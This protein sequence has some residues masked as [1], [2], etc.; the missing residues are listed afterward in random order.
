MIK[1]CIKSKNYNIKRKEEANG[2]QACVEEMQKTNWQLTERKNGRT[3]R[4]NAISTV[5]NALKGHAKKLLE[6]HISFTKSVIYSVFSAYHQCHPLNHRLQKLQKV[7]SL[8]V[9]WMC[10]NIWPKQFP[11][12]LIWLALY[13]CCSVN[14]RLCTSNQ[15]GWRVRM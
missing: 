11:T 15:S 3:M 2:H 1:W 7:Y 12:L 4:S 8:Q 6:Y 5:C 9:A 14:H 13:S 10:L